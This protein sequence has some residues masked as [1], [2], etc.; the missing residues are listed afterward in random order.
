MAQMPPRFCPQCG[1][2]VPAGQRFCSNCGVTMDANFGK[3]T[4]ASSSNPRHSQYPDIPAQLPDG[5]MPVQGG[6]VPPPPPEQS[7]T[8]PPAAQPP[9]ANYS[10]EPAQGYAQ[11]N[12]AYG[13]PVPG[14]QPVQ[15]V[16]VYAKPQKDSSKG[17]LGQIG[18]GVLVIILIVLAVCGASGYFAYRWVSGLAS[19][20][21]VTSTNNGTG[22]ST[23][24]N[25]ITPTIAPLS[26]KMNA[27]VTY[28][29]VAITLGNVQEASSF[30]DDANANSPVLLRV[31]ITE[32]NPTTGSIYLFY[33]D[34][35]RLL[36]PD[37][38]SVVPVSEQNSGGID[39]A[40][41][42]QNWVDFPLA[43]KMDISKLTLQI[44]APTEAQ[45]KIPLTA[46]ADVSKYQDKTI[47]PNSTF[48]YA[49]LTWT[50]TTVTSSLSADGKQ[51][52]T[53][54]RYITVALKVNNPTSNDYYPFFDS[55]MRLSAGSSVVP[56]TS[57]TFSRITAGTTDTTGTETFLVPQN[58]S[59]FILTLL[60]R[61]DITPPVTQA[62]QTFQI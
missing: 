17:V 50:L 33:N 37:G 18:C 20:S 49:G 6:A 15:P 59:S 26:L 25:S 2:A 44:G 27:A 12:P 45:M 21:P 53:G 40:V 52:T 23:P 55:N 36:L 30:T 43:S 22:N 9:Y 5:G 10:T 28:A 19:N 48:Q 58:S 61:T 34:N 31:N 29:S 3:P 38:T 41:N 35:F 7:F 14:M 51:A 32:H 56:P 16:P 1:T 11:S 46:N 13:Q 62:T 60:A 4:A 47:S 8:P 39:Q 24:A 42:R 57:S 54:N